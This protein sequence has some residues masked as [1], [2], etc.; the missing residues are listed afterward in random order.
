MYRRQHFLFAKLTM[1]FISALA[2]SLVVL[3]APLQNIT[4]TV[5]DGTSN[6]G[7]PHLL[8]TPTKA[9]DIAAFFLGNYLA[10]VASMISL[11]GEAPIPV[12]L[13]MIATLF[14]PV[15]GVRRGIEAIK[16]R[17]ILHRRTPL[18]TA[19]K[20]GA[21]AE[22][23]R[24]SRWKPQ[25]NDRIHGIELPHASS[26]SNLQDE[27]TQ[28]TQRTG[29]KCI[30]AN[31]PGPQNEGG[32]VSA[33]LDTATSPAE[34]FLPVASAWSFYGRKVHGRCSLPEGYALAIIPPDANL[35][36]CDSP[37]KTSIDISSSY[38]VPRAL[39]SIYQLIFASLTLYRTRGDQ[40][41]R[42]GYA[43][44]GLTVTPYL[45]MSFVNLVGSFLTPTYSHVYLV[46]TSIM[47]EARLRNG[48]FDGTVGKIT[49][50]CPSAEG[51]QQSSNEFHEASREGASIPLQL[52]VWLDRL[53]FSRLTYSAISKGKNQSLEWELRLLKT[54]KDEKLVFTG[55]H[56]EEYMGQKMV[57][58]PCSVT[59]HGSTNKLSRT[60]IMRLASAWIGCL[61]FA[62]IGGLS[63]FDQG[64]STNVQRSWTMAWLVTGVVL[65]PDC[66]QAIE[67]LSNSVADLVQ[68]TKIYRIALFVAFFLY[69]A[70]TVGGMV[71]VGQMLKDYGSCIRMY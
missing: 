16:R 29:G 66:Y 34:C 37:D 58:V 40:L 70:A 67:T 1:A 69:G 17:A 33:R 35:C 53:M 51:Q 62:I 38:S 6:H 14:Y 55:E 30:T 9:T 59:Q 64:K 45:I 18:D 50:Q 63:H 65:G 7:D 36:Y 56:S 5:P 41:D 4:I 28:T 39:V 48:D 43:A 49:N 46:Q 25:P 2:F 21:L 60:L 31:D 13:S 10:H 44:F 27:E 61:S 68:S 15:S 52:V 23:V 32:A 71:V 3:A 24:T 20:A 22:V 26:T 57:Q 11:P 47:E 12:F 54:E 8:C 19:L 42:Y